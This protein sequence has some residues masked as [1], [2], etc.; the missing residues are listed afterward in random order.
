ML[1]AGYKVVILCYINIKTSETRW[2]VS[3]KVNNLITRNFFSNSRIYLCVNT[4]ITFV[5]RD[6]ELCLRLLLEVG[7]TIDIRVA[8]GVGVPVCV[9]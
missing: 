7:A 3:N 5:L 1:A 2:I 4:G 8:G 9:K 6:S